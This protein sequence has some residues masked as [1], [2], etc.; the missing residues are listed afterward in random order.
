MGFVRKT[1]FNKMWAAR[2]TGN[3]KRAIGRFFGGGRKGAGF[4]N[5]GRAARNCIYRRTTISGTTFINVFIIY[6]L[7]SLKRTKETRFSRNFR[8]IKEKYEELLK[9]EEDFVTR[10]VYK[11][12]I[13]INTEF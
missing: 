6:P 5:P 10:L 7:L 4:L 3:L 8:L 2:G 9:H 12:I 11:F 1:S 13:L